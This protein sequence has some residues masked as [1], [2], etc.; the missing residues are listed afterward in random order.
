[1][2]TTGRCY[3]SRTHFIRFLCLKR[4]LSNYNWLVITHV[5]RC[6]ENTERERERERENLEINSSFSASKPVNAWR[7]PTFDATIP[8][9][10]NP[11]H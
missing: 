8:A 3:Q 11:F 1:V 2:A 5:I 9:T 10:N 7:F 6:H 4:A